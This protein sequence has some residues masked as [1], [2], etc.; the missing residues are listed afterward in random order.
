ML[1]GGSQ[2]RVSNRDDLQ[3]LFSL[4]SPSSNAADCFNYIYVD[5]DQMLMKIGSHF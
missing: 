4:L 1:N 3:F 2:E 5:L